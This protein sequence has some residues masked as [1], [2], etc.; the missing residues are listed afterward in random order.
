MVSQGR[1]PF[2]SQHPHASVQEQQ[3][4]SNEGQKREK[5]VEMLK[6]AELVT[7]PS[8][9]AMTCVVEQPKALVYFYEFVPHSIPS[10]LQAKKDGQSQEI[11]SMTKN[12]LNKKLA[13]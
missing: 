1:Y 7:N 9:I 10:Y 5:K 11:W 12:L 2:G 8:V 4:F 3:E 13:Y 6:K